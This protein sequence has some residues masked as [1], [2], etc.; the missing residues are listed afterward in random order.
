MT[1]QKPWEAKMPGV[2]RKLKKTEKRTWAGPREI[3]ENVKKDLLALAL[4]LRMD[5]FTG[6]LESLKEH[7]IG[8]RNWE[9]FEFLGYDWYGNE[10]ISRY[11]IRF[12]TAEDAMAYKLF[13]E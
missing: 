7:K 3:P 6:L 10:P 9:E 2:A 5:E 11:I 8:L 12:R 4:K 1:K 13:Y